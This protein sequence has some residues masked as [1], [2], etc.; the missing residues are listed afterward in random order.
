MSGECDKNAEALMK[1]MLQPYIEQYSKFYQE[2]IMTGTA[3]LDVVIPTDE[4]PSSRSQ[5][6]GQWIKMS[7]RLPDDGQE[8]WIVD[9]TNEVSVAKFR[10]GGVRNHCGHWCDGFILDDYMDMTVEKTKHWQ[11]LNIPNPPK[12]E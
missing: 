8:C 10:R 3:R 1:Q 7:D 5:Q 11:P 6:N 4:E 9:Y 2:L 12:D